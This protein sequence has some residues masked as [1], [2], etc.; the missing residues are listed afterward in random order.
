MR[1]Q[2]RPCGIVYNWS[3]LPLLRNAGCPNCS[4]PLIRAPAVTRGENIWRNPLVFVR[5]DAP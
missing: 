4:A 3:D 2:C 1:G 5:K